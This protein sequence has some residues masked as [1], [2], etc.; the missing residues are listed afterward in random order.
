MDME[1]IGEIQPDVPLLVVAVHHE[2]EH[3]DT[4]LPILITGVGKLSASRS[5]LGALAPL[6]ADRRPGMLLNLGSAGALHDGIEGTH[7]VG[8]LLQ[9]DLDGAAIAAMV[10]TDPSPPIV[11]GEGLTLATGDRFI[12][13]PVERQR[14]AQV[15]HLVDME[16]YAV[17]SAAEV[18]GLDLIVIKH[19]SDQADGEAQDRWIDAVALSSKELAAWLDEHH[20]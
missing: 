3:L 2:A 5:V 14:L 18:L 12:A 13:D 4:D 6:P 9:H 17:A 15:A 10:G 8:T 11:V 19:V 1:I 7:V 16:G 20:H